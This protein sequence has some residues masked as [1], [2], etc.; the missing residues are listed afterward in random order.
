MC[1][2]ARR[3]SDSIW[4]WTWTHLCVEKER[5]FW[6]FDLIETS[7]AERH[8]GKLGNRS[9]DEL[10]LKML[11]MILQPAPIQRA[12]GLQLDFWSHK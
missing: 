6:L 9:W 1:P 5:V 11:P 2:R 3:L 4:V 12:D 10:Y 8:S 7:R